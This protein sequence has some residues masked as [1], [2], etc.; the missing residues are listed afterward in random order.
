MARTNHIHRLQDELAGANAALAQMQ[1]E[2][3]D[4]R[5]H[6]TSAKFHNDPTIQVGDVLLRLE[7][8]VDR[9]WSA[10]YEGYWGARGEGA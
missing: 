10:K 6:L 8:M 4:F 5:T 7:Q 2:V 9:I 1:D 3:R